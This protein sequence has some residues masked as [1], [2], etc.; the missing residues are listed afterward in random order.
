M[1]SS[2]NV[3]G[4][5]FMCGAFQELRV[6]ARPSESTQAAPALSKPARSRTGSW[7]R[8]RLE[9]P[10]QGAVRRP[11]ARRTVSSTSAIMRNPTNRQ[12][13]TGCKH[14]SE[15]TEPGLWV[16]EPGRP[17][18]RVCP[19]SGAGLL[20]SC[21]R[22]WSAAS[23]LIPWSAP[24]ADSRCARHWPACSTVH[25]RRLNNAVDGLTRIRG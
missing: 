12:S 8:Y 3:S 16:R 18:M 2:A 25:F 5:K 20:R 22:P 23:L 17:H 19:E 24:S 1:T 10:L 15:R 11:S 6:P 7:R 4:G 13:G 14:P 9:V 21:G